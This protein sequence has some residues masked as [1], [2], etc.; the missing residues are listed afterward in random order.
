MK[1]SQ[2]KAIKVSKKCDDIKSNSE[3]SLSQVLLS[4]YIY[5]YIYI[6][7]EREKEKEGTVQVVT[8]VVYNVKW[9]NNS[10]KGRETHNSTTG[11]CNLKHKSK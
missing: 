7:R 9:K 10:F 5:I 6:C 11:I 1:L 8:H 2:V 3:P 4:Q